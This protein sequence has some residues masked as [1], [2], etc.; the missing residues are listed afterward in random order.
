MLNKLNWPTWVHD[1]LK[2]VA[3]GGLIFLGLALFAGGTLA[4][5]HWL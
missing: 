1:A 3:V 5:V 2:G 4:L